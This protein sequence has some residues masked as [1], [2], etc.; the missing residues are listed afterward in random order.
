MTHSRMFLAALVLVVTAAG[1]G[2]AAAQDAAPDT[3]TDPRPTAETPQDAVTPGIR[4]ERKEV[5]E[6]MRLG[7]IEHRQRL[8]TI[9]RLAQ[10]AEERGD[11]RRVALLDVLSVKEYARYHRQF[12]RRRA[13]VNDGAFRKAQLVLGKGRTRAAVAEEMAR[14]AARVL[15]EEKMRARWA[16]RGIPEDDP[17][18]QEALAR[19]ARDAESGSDTSGEST[20]PEPGDETPA[21]EEDTLVFPG[22]PAIAAMEMIPTQD[23]MDALAP[24]R[25][26]QENADAAYAELKAVLDADP[27]SR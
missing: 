4:P 25:I 16:K 18:V 21:G 15:P 20:D 1:P 19:L 6:A 24:E 26:S 7:E 5:L 13:Q 22:D 23:E 9:H 10:L 14:R 17:R 3:G 27:D 11:A 2:M 8:A 12:E